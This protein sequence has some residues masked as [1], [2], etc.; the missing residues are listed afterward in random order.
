MLKDSQKLYRIMP[1]ERFFQMLVDKKNTLVSPKSWDDPFEILIDKD[2]IKDAKQYTD[3]PDD[4]PLKSLDYTGWYGQCWSCVK[5][6]DS[7][8][9]IYSKDKKQ[10]CVKIETTVERLRKSTKSCTNYD[11]IFALD[12]VKYG[13]VENGGFLEQLDSWLEKYEDKYIGRI[14]DVL[15][16]LLTKRDTFEHEKEVRLLAHV[17]RAKSEEVFAYKINPSELI[18]RVILDPW[19]PKE[20]VKGIKTAI[21]ECAGEHKIIIVNSSLYNKR[22]LNNILLRSIYTKQQTG[23]HTNE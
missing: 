12:A 4:A 18:T 11:A 10:R 7:L 13:N 23:N 2:F 22:W 15:S 8:W 19:T 14:I 3:V 5:E 16:L 1:L 20:A 6:S 17:P 21:R 9:R